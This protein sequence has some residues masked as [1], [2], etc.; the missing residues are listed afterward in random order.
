[1]PTV[2]STQSGGD[3]SWISPRFGSHRLDHSLVSVGAGEIQGCAYDHA[4]RSDD[5][6]DHAVL[7]TTI[8]LKAGRE[9]A[10]AIARDEE[11]P[12]RVTRSA[13][14]CRGAQTC[15]KLL[16]EAGHVRIEPVMCPLGR[17]VQCE[18]SDLVRLSRI[19]LDPHVLVRGEHEPERLTGRAIR[20]N[21]TPDRTHCSVVS[22]V[23]VE[24]CHACHQ[25][26]H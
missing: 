22:L 4:T 6:S 19:G 26:V 10:T 16:S 1:M 9:P 17:V 21:G 24:G 8:G 25:V 7:L 3:H 2:S 13:H 18:P 15:Q 12:F 20:N 23:P 11:Q 5:L 14:Q